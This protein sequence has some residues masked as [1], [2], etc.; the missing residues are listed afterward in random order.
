MGV[1]RKRVLQQQEA[2]GGPGL[3]GPQLEPAAAVDLA[4][5]PEDHAHQAAAQGQAQSA[6]DPALAQQLE[7]TILQILQT[8]KT[9]ATC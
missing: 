6:E 1:K 8:R 9:G 2:P 4:E 3:R 5:A 7:D